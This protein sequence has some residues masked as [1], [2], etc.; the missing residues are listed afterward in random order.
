MAQERFLIFQKQFSITSS[1]EDNGPIV[2]K[3]SWQGKFLHLYVNNG[4]RLGD[5]NVLQMS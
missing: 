4:M 1:E 3:T 2:Q 5:N